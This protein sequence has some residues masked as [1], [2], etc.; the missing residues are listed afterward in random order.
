MES[1]CNEDVMKDPNT[2][3][4]L[5]QNISNPIRSFTVLIPLRSIRSVQDDN[6]KPTLVKTKAGGR[7]DTPIYVKNIFKI[8]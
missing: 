2:L 6:K 3:P 7:L 1:E 4:P 8:V 5:L